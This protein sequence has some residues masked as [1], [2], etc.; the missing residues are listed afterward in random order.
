MPVLLN[1]FGSTAVE[2]SYFKKKNFF[3]PLEKQKTNIDLH[4]NT[5]E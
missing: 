5:G 1:T 4:S 2:I 3:F